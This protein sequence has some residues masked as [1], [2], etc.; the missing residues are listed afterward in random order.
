MRQPI[1][2]VFFDAAETLF[3]VNGSV[4]EIY[5]RHAVRFGYQPKPESMALISEAFRR[6]F[7]DAPPPVFAPGGPAHVREAASPPPAIS[8]IGD[9][10]T[11][12]RLSSPWSSRAG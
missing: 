3:H 6:A 7:H 11:A 12:A 2:V 8:R 10:S 5:F 4:A 9:R 1:R